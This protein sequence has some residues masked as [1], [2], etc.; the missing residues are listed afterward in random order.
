LIELSIGLAITS[1]VLAGV[2]AGVQKMMEQ[3]NVNRTVTQITTAAEKIRLIIKRDSDTSFVSLPNLTSA[4]NNA[5]ATSNVINP[6]AAG[7]QVFNALGNQVTVQGAGGTSTNQHFR[8]WLQNVTPSTCAELA[9]ALEGAATTVWIWNN[10]WQVV[11]DNTS[12]LIFDAANARRQCLTNAQNA[13][14]LEFLK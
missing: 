3:V 9:G 1:L 5:F 10:G 7:V 2:V 11:K 14:W 8:I 13:I 12:S 4:V 6:G